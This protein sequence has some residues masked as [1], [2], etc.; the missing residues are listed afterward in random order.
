M[1]KH[2]CFGTPP[3]VGALFWLQTSVILSI[4]I[5]AIILPWPDSHLS[6]LPSSPRCCLC[7][8]LIWLRVPTSLEKYPQLRRIYYWSPLPAGWYTF[9]HTHIQSRFHRQG[10]Q[11]R[12]T[13]NIMTEQIDCE[14]KVFPE[15]LLRES[16]PLIQLRVKHL[17]LDSVCADRWVFMLY[18]PLQYCTTK[19]FITLMPFQWCHPE[20]ILRNR[21]CQVEFWL[22]EAPL[23]L[24][25]WWPSVAAGCHESGQAGEGLR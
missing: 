17:N 15:R 24:G 6:K 14:R 12:Y 19:L 16:W 18:C 1:R 4:M 9:I 23:R 5:V 2:F 11:H 22:A 20:V 8:S 3:K 21:G 13:E 7:S 25:Q 10:V